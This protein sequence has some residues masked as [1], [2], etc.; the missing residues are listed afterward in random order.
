MKMPL[1]LPS[2]SASR[3]SALSLAAKRISMP[4]SL[5]VMANIVKVP[6]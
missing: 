6:P 3:S 2:T 4:M 1:V 5:R